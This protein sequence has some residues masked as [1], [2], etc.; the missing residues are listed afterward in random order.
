MAI[1]ILFSARFDASRF[2]AHSGAI[3]SPE[4]IL[5]VKALPAL[6]GMDGEC[7]QNLERDLPATAH[8]KGKGG[9]GGRTWGSQM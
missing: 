8:I 5:V 9:S 3:K 2:M 4:P 1:K 6:A 7:A